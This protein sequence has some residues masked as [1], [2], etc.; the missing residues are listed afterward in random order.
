MGLIQKAKQLAQSLVSNLNGWGQSIILLAPNGFN[1]TIG[2]LHKKI[3]LGVD[4]E[5]NIVNSLTATVTVS[6]LDLANAN[7]PY[8]DAYGEVKLEGHKVYVADI[9]G[10]TISYMVQSWHPDETLGLIVIYL[11]VLD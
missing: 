1:I 5:G 7:Y 4:T 2:G 10:N 8:R 3:R 6:D 9:T 11:Q